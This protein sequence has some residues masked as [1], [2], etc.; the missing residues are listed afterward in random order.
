[1]QHSTTCTTS[2]TSD[3]RKFLSLELTK[4]LVHTFVTPR[5]DYCTSLLSSI[6]ASQLKKVQRVLNAAAGLICRVPQ[7][8]H[9]LLLMQDLHWLPIRHHIHFKVLLFTIKEIHGIAP[10]Y[11]QDFVLLKS[12]GVYCLRSARGILLMAPSIRMKVTLGDR[13]FQVAAPKLWN[14]LPHEIRGITSVD[15]FKHHLKTYFY[16]SKWIMVIILNIF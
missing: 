8:C 5:V 1:M 10:L 6:P 7:Y 4:I 2:V 12:Q 13:S 9:I 11:I 16:S 14:L 15:V 3:I